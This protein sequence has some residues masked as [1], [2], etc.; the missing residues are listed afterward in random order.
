MVGLTF[1]A[2]GSLLI[3]V[4][5]TPT[6]GDSWRLIHTDADAFAEADLNGDGRVSDYEFA[7]FYDRRA[8]RPPSGPAVVGVP[9]T[10]SDNTFTPDEI[11]PDVNLNSLYVA[12][13]APPSSDGYDGHPYDN[14]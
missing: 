13:A 9:S 14:Y 2:L 11:Y 10:Y 6:I 7:L 5:A 4:A 12:P 3:S 1:A 8:G